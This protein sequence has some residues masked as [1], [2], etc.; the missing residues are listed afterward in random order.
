MGS[1]NNICFCIDVKRIVISV[2]IGV[3]LAVFIYKV[4]VEPISNMLNEKKSETAALNYYLDSF[5]RFKRRLDKSIDHNRM[6]ETDEI[7][8]SKLKNMNNQFMCD[9][10]DRV[11]NMEVNLEYKRNWIIFIEERPNEVLPD[12]LD[13]TRFRRAYAISRKLYLDIA[14]LVYVICVLT[15]MHSIRVAEDFNILTSAENKSHEERVKEF[16]AVSKLF[17]N[18]IGRMN[19]IIK[20]QGLLQVYENIDRYLH[21]YPH[22]RTSR[23][24][25]IRNEIKVELLRKKMDLTEMFNVFIFSAGAPNT[26]AKG[27]IKPGWFALRKLK[28]SMMLLT[29]RLFMSDDINRKDFDKNYAETL[30]NARIK[31]LS[32][33][34]DENSE[35][36]SSTEYS[37]TRYSTTETGSTETGSTETGSTEYSTTEYSTTETGSTETDSTEYSSE[38]NNSEYSETNEY[39]SEYSNSE[40]EDA[41]EL[42]S[43]QAVELAD[44]WEN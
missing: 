23:Y 9:L 39:Y 17:M 29:Y 34:E 25:R 4:F 12:E 15:F 26:P 38:S 3:I 10:V 36:N 20:E 31:P 33:D 19:N 37:S 28:P 42:H 41:T 24:P 40:E 27:T 13:D 43:D 18:K 5:N 22:A 6:G 8:K 7:A 21:D 32:V 30:I 11:M 14:E 16:T 2:I 44:L 1:E 35:S